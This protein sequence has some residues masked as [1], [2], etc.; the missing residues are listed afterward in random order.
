MTKIENVLPEPLQASMLK[1]A[2]FG[3]PHR[4]REPRS[5]PLRE[6]RR[7][8]GDDCWAWLH[9]VDAEG[10]ETERTIVPLGLYF[11]GK[12]WLVA[13]YCWLRSDYRSFRVDRVRELRLVPADPRRLESLAIPISLDE[14]VRAM[15]AKE[16]AD[17]A[18][19]R[20]TSS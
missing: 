17:R 1:T 3:P 16:A 11:W 9:Y 12:Q 15:E 13:A 2:L 14:Y 20:G 8:I 19:C 10:T 18:S 4:T 7:A 6:L 5:G